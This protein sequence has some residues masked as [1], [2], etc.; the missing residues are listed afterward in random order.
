MRGSSDPIAGKLRERPLCWCVHRG[1]PRSNCGRIHPCR[2]REAGHR[3]GLPRTTNPSRSSHRRREGS[4]LLRLLSRSPLESA[5]PGT[6]RGRSCWSSWSAPPE[7]RRCGARPERGDR[8]P[9]CWRSRGY[10]GH[11]ALFLRSVPRIQAS[12][13]PRLY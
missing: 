4:T 11:R 12:R 2:L 7:D 3:R 13:T 1:R 8:L 5:F 9:L 10:V 6:A